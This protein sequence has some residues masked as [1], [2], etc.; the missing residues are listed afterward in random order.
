MFLCL[1]FFLVSQFKGGNLFLKK[2][3][4]KLLIKSESQSLDVDDV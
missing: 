4:M 1:M 2:R 3:T